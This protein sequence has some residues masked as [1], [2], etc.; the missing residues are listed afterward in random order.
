MKA[1]KVEYTVKP[2]YIE[3]N[4]RNI[5]VVMD[6]LKKNPIEGMWYKAFLLEDGQTFM[7]LNLSKDSEIA[8]KLNEVKQFNNFR[9]ELKASEPLSSPKA[10]NLILISEDY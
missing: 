6:E 4:K 8:S 2:E 10:E 1:I 7:H 9:K 5:K 3:T